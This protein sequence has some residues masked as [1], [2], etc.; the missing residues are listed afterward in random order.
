MSSGQKYTSAQINT[1]TL[2]QADQLAKSMCEYLVESWKQYQRHGSFTTPREWLT[3]HYP[4]LLPYT[5]TFA[6]VLLQVL[7]RE[8][9]VTPR[10]D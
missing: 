9:G 3:T 2:A 5:E 1:F 10:S 6:R 4:H 8:F 7:E